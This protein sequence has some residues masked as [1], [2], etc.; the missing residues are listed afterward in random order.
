MRHFLNT[1][2]KHDDE[3]DDPRSPLI[4][5]FPPEIFLQGRREEH[6]SVLA[7]PL[8]AEPA[9]VRQCQGVRERQA[10]TGALSTVSGTPPGRSTQSLLLASV[11]PQREPY[12]GDKCE[13]AED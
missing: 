13:E 10:P 5:Q 11:P 2:N 6:P 8:V 12:E 3:Y 9:V 4:Q 7:R 1:F